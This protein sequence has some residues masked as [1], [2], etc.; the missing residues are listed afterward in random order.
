MDALEYEMKKVRAALELFEGVKCDLPIGYQKIVC[1]VIRNVN[2][3]ENFRRKY[4]LV[5]GD[6]TTTTPMLLT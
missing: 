4:R 5:P 6:H 3:V 2:I 1:H